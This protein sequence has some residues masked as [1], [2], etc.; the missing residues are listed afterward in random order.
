MKTENRSYILFPFNDLFINEFQYFDIIFLWSSLQDELE[1]TKE[2]WNSH[3]IRPSNNKHVPHGCP[4]AMYMLPELYGTEDY[5]CQVSEDLT[6]CEDY[7]THRSDIACDDDVFTLCTHIM[8]QNSLHVP[9]D[10]YM[11]IDLY[12]F[13]RG[14]LITILNLDR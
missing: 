8:A 10:V 3:A 7:C 6:R 13:L 4:N 9:V 11:A 5:L 1:S 14:E 2:S 12:L